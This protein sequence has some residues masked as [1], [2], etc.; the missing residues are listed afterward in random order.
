MELLR[1]D[2]ARALQI[3]DIDILNYRDIKKLNKRLLNIL[4]RYRGLSFEVA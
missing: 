1:Y 3:L 4:D 2:S